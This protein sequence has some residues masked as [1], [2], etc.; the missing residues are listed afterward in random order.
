MEFQR[1]QLSIVPCNCE[2]GKYVF[3]FQVFLQEAV[4]ANELPQDGIEREEASER[5][6]AEVILLISFLVKT[7]T[8][9]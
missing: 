9:Y 7:V 6:A 1:I 2:F 4:E 5:L 8:L 3:T